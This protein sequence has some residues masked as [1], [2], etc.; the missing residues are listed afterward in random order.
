MPPA[1]IE[2]GIATPT[3]LAFIVVNKYVDSMPLARQ[4]ASFAR[5]G[6]EF[7][8][9]RMADWIMAVGEAAT[10]VVEQPLFD[11]RAGPILLADETTV[12][13]L[14]EED[15]PDTSKS[16]MWVGYGGP[17]ETPVVYYRNATGR[18]TSEVQALIGKFSGYRQTD[19]FEAYH[20]P[21]RERVGLVHVGCWAHVRRKFFDAKG[22]S[23]KTCAAEQAI[24]MI[25]RLY[26]PEREL[27][28]LADRDEFLTERRARVEPVLEQ[29]KT[30]LEK[31]TVHA[32]PRTALG[33]AL[34]YA[35][36]QSHKLIRYLD[37]ADLAPDTHRIENKIRPFVIG[38]TNWLQSGSPR[39]ASASAG[40]SRLIETPKA[41]RIDPY[42]YMRTLIASLPAVTSTDSDRSLLPY[43]ISLD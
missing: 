31:K 20:R 40:I 35:L 14:G 22:N 12:Q 28:D 8:R 23:K 18:A 1:V 38:R 37:H 26:Q 34:S 6:V 16:F 17:P 33:K 39:A 13:V 2:R 21:V 29:M 43:T 24:A 41:N 32:P 3:L 19:G 15:R 27:S 9:Q 7:P 42:R 36:G 5:L 4:E 11:L 10:P 25:S 30:S